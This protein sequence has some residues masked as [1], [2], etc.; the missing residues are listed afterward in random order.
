M[1]GVSGWRVV[2]GEQRTSRHRMVAWGMPKA[3]T[4]SPGMEQ[5]SITTRGSSHFLSS[6]LSEEPFAVGSG[7]ARIQGLFAGS[8]TRWPMMASRAINLS[9]KLASKA[10]SSNLKA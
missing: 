4:G 10:N 6:S 1:I 5:R 7:A 2:D 9:W 3:L 8:V